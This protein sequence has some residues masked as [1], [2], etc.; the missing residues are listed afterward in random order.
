MHAEDQK[1]ILAVSDKGIGIPTQFQPRVFDK[2]FRVPT[3]D[4]HD[5]KGHGLGLSYVHSVIEKHKGSIQLISQ[6]G[7]GTTFTIKLPRNQ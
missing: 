2:F 4:Q 6:E 7:Q 5:R 3:G 1:V